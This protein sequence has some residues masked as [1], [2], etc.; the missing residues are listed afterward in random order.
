MKKL[1]RFRYPSL[2]CFFLFLFA[3]KL[4]AQEKETQWAQTLGSPAVEIVKGVAHDNDGNVYITGA[5]EGPITVTLADNT[6][7][8]VSSTGLKDIYVAKINS[9]GKYIW[10]KTYGCDEGNDIG[11]KIKIDSNGDLIV[12]GDFFSTVDFNESDTEGGGIVVSKGGTDAFI[13]KLAASDGAFKWVKSVGG[14]SIDNATG[15][16]VDSANNIFIGGRFGG[17]VDFDPG[18]GIFNLTSKAGANSWNSFVLKLDTDGNFAWAKRIGGIDASTTCNI[19]IYDMY[20]ANNRIYLTGRYKFG[21]NFNPDDA[22]AQ[23]ENAVKESS[24]VL[25]LT[26]QG[27]YQW[28]RAITG[29]G[30]PSISAQGYGVVAD[31][32]GHVF[33]VGTYREFNIYPAISGESSLEEP[34]TNGDIYIIKF[35]NNGKVT[36]SKRIG[37]ASEDV[38]EGV[39]I[40]TKGDIYVT[41]RF[42][43]TNIDFGNGIL[44]SAPG[45]F[46]AFIVKVK[47]DGITKWV[48]RIGGT[49]AELVG[50]DTAYIGKID[51]GQAISVDKDYNIYTAGVFAGAAIFDLP[52]PATIKFRTLGGDDVF[53]H[54]LGQPDVLPVH[55]VY[56]NGKKES[57]KNSLSWQTL[58]ENNNSHFILQRSTDGVM[59][60]DVV[61]IEGH[62]NTSSVN[63]YFYTDYVNLN[64]VIYYRLAQVDFSGHITYSDIIPIRNKWNESIVYPNP[65]IETVTLKLEENNGNTSVRVMDTAG[66][67]V[68]TVSKVTGNEIVLNLKSLPNGLYL[69]ELKNGEQIQLYKVIKQAN[70][71][72]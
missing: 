9:E 46:D 1:L 18:L 60:S 3:E 58:N 41:G 64:G 62:G 19:T 25:T 61:T 5:I 28:Y 4:V 68:Y 12:I 10:I 20:T 55:L 8:T 50:E 51:K 13:L 29:P 23:L 2:V 67:N 35:D 31:N 52:V 24:F 63:N 57:G 22:P 33:A 44:S 39:A 37:A 34:G 21:V 66:R 70:K 71:N 40:D 53:I 42:A 49:S 15:L 56:F 27:V 47:N 7:T 69:V 36:W 32:S 59:F 45:Q 54:K 14:A 6:S 48:H 30:V 43:G 17:T 65:F 16:S 38:A 26:D 72:N 11:N